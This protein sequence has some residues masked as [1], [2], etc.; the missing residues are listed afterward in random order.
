MKRARILVVE[1]EPIIGMDIK[2]I[3]LNIGYDVPEV[4]YSGK[5]AIQKADELKP[6][7]I[8]MDI[9]LSGEID[10]IDA[11]ERIQEKHDIPVIYLTAHTDDGTFKRARNTNPYGYL[12]KPTGK[13]DLYTAIETALHRHEM[14]VSL[15]ESEERYRTILE[16]IEEGYFEVDLSGHYTFSNDA[17]CKIYRIARD[18]LY[19]MSYKQHMDESTAREIYKI[20]NEMYRKKDRTKTYE[21]EI[22]GKDGCMVITE[23]IASLIIDS[24]GKPV[25]FRGIVRDITERKKIEN[26]LRESEAKYRKQFDEALDAIFV[27]DA[28]TGILIDCNNA[29]TKLVGREKSDLIGKHQ[30]ILHPQEEVKEEFSRTFKLHLIEKE[31]QSIETQVIKKNGESIDVSIK[32]NLF[33]SNGKKFIQGIFRDITEIKNA[34]KKMKF[35]HDLVIA[36]SGVTKLRDALTLVL[37]A[38]IKIEGMD[39]G[40]IYLLDKDSGSFNLLYSK[41]LSAEFTEIASPWDKDSENAKLMM[42]GKPSYIKYDKEFLNKHKLSPKDIRIREGL[43]SVAVIPILHLGEVVA[44][45]NIASHE[46][47]EISDISRNYLETLASQIGNVIVRLRAE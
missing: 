24:A 39:C 14:E 35:H 5:E 40:G 36:L 1:D 45:M 47:M 34:E 3:L 13:N 38:A 19:G 31:G 37:D 43:K 4:V 46:V 23:A 29:A 18:E 10:G 33:E 9:V 26:S 42:K 20:Y 22:I 27:A 2:G 30:R 8:L 21:I 32:A 7:I 28:E 25:G 16:H 12:L 6:D 15:R 11:V 44:C 17:F 41:V